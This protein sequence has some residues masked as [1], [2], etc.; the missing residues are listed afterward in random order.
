MDEENTLPTGMVFTGHMSPDTDSVM[1][2]VAAAYLWKGE[3]AVSADPN[4]ESK[5]CLKKWGAPEPK[6]TT[7]PSFQGKDWG[8]V[9]HGSISKVP[10]GVVHARIKMV[11]DHH[12]LAED[13]VE[14][15]KP[16]YINIRPW[17]STNTIM[18]YV[19]VDNNIDI[20]EREGTSSVLEY[21]CAA[22]VYTRMCGGWWGRREN[23]WESR[24]PPAR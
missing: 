10:P 24:P 2:A 7:H 21:V 20:P 12:A 18:A 13:E 15:P 14:L 4:M 1:S 8:L 3:A 6:L 16:V 5:W 11:L 22:D 19:Y 17:G 9:D 23:R